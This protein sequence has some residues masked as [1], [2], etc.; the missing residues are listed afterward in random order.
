[1]EL[2]NATHI[3]VEAGVRYWEDAAVNGVQEDD[4]APTIYGAENGAWGVR[5]DLERGRIEG[6]PE[7]MTADI[8]Y[9]VCDDGQYWLTDSAGQRLAKWRGY[10]VPDDFLC[11]GEDGFGDYIIMHVDAGGS[12]EN[13]RAPL[14][15]PDRWE[16]TP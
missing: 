1:M 16:P 5:I 7:G 15:D 2:L 12:I 11:P 4:D 3:E 6:W 14:I 9:K 13:W 10:Y 8:H